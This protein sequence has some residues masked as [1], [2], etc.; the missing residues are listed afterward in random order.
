MIPLFVGAAA[1]FLA[2][3]PAAYRAALSTEHMLLHRLERM[4][5]EAGS[6]MGGPLAED[7]HPLWH[8][9]TEER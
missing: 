8:A 3:R 2:R 4:R 1:L 7:F 9:A 6:P 5:G